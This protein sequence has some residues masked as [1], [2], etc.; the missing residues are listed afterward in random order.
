M[1]RLGTMMRKNKIRPPAPRVFTIQ[2]TI[3]QVCGRRLTSDFGLKNGMGPKCMHK[4]QLMHAP[5][6]PAQMTL[7]EDGNEEDTTADKHD[8]L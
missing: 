3:C 5:P 7:W 4:W 1:N 2:V 8:T 6:D